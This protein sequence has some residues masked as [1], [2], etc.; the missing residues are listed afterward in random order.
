MSTKPAVT[1]A[2]LAELV[3]LTLKH[4]DST[5]HFNDCGCCVCLHPEGREHNKTGY[6]INSDGDVSFHDTRTDS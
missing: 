5:W 3:R 6:V 2:Q 4:P 1:T